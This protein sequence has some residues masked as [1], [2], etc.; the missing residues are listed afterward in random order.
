MFLSGLVVG[1]IITIANFSFFTSLLMFFIS[2]SILT[3]WKGEIKKRQ[4]SEYKEGKITFDIAQ[5]SKLCFI[6]T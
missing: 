3:K 5:R 4:D 1:F 2:S 6:L